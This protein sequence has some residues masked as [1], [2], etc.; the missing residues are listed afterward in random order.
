MTVIYSK[1]V[2]T[3]YVKY[4]QTLSGEK[5]RS[6]AN[7]LRSMLKL[8]PHCMKLL[9]N[10]TIRPTLLDW[11]LAVSFLQLL[12]RSLFSSNRWKSWEPLF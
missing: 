10:L 12:F 6:F 9:G 11:C 7:S 8:R 5:C 2:F 1:D 3:Y 4:F